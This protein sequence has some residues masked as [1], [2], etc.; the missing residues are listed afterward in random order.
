MSQKWVRSKRWD[1][2]HLSGALRPVKFV[3]RAFSSIWLA[4]V[5]LTLVAVYGVLASVPLGMLALA[6]TWGFYVLTLVAAVAVGA[7][8]PVWAVVRAMGSAGA[9]QA[10]RFSVGLLGFLGLSCVSALAWHAWAW[11]VLRYDAVTGEGVRFFA[12]FAQRY[13]SVT[14]RRLPGLEM[15]ELEFY[16]WWPLRVILLAFVANMVVATVRRIEFKFVNI[17]VLLVHTGI[18]T[19]ALGSVYYQRLKQEGDVLL[20]AGAPDDRGVAR[21]GP[22][23]RG[24]YDNT[25]VA[26]WVRQ[27]GPWE[28]RPLS[29]VP[30]YNEYNL[31]ALGNGAARGDDGGRT[32]SIDV[33]P[34]PDWVPV[35]QRHVDEDVRFRVVGYASYADLVG[36]WEPAEPPADGAANPVRIVDLLARG[37]GADVEEAPAGSFEFMPRRAAQRATVFERAFGLEYTIGMGRERW[38]DLTEELPGG[39]L[40]G[41][42]VEAPHAGVRRVFGVEEGDV[43]EVEETGHRLEVRRLSPEPPFP[44]ITPGYEGAESSVAVVRVEPPGGGDAFDRW[45]Y[46]RFPE[47]AQDLVDDSAGA[48][49][50]TRRMADESIRISYVDASLLQVYI[51]EPVDEEGSGRVRAIVRP[52]GRDAQVVDLGDGT[53]R[54]RLAPRVSLTVRERW[55]HAVSVE[56]PRV[57]PEYERD[58]QAVGTHDRAAL[59]VE[60]TLD[61]PEHAGWRRVVWMPFTQY[62]AISSETQREVALPDGRRISLVFG[63]MRHRLPGLALQLVDFE[64]I[65]YPHSSVPRDYRSDVLVLS[66]WHGRFEQSVRSTSLN[67]PLL[68][69]V[70]FQ[71]REDVPAFVNAVGWMLS[72]IAPTQYKFSQAGWD[73]EGWRETKELADQGLLPRPS[74]RFTILGVGNN[75]GIYVIAAGAVMMSVG[76]PWAFY[77]KPLIL[78]RR[79]RLLQERY[80]GVRGAGGE[81]VGR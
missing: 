57:I 20:L 5:L 50:P 12:E 77:I 16:G 32:L 4:V 11:P 25:V 73:A 18:V 13:E 8:V 74:A 39:A 40:H 6:P 46:H 60:V 76:I 52:P 79:K 27:D 53:G 36:G 55:E 30:R 61:G 49:M 45:V 9:G 10:S 66:S 28:Q 34:A 1:D 75:P 17:G 22:M 15:T 33:P 69:R 48:A 64:M 72:H 63:R 26:L 23:E 54:L 19:I 65:P 37:E 21:A 38:R 3:L 59:A 71:P 81:G 47:I 62:M 14:V 78:R 7:G 58:R 43:V 24:F 44:I 67:A 31:D 51:D 2:E 80:A 42:V 41:L 35:D 70:P 29:G 56:V 68:I